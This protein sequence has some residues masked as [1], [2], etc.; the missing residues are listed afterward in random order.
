MLVA[1]FR[2]LAIADI[3]N[4]YGS[5]TVNYRGHNYQSDELTSS[6]QG[7]VTGEATF[8]VVSDGGIG[9]EKQKVGFICYK[10]GSRPYG[11]G[12]GA[13]D[14]NSYDYN[15]KHN[16]SKKLIWERLKKGL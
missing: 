3:K 16:E 11:T 5:T 8:E 9:N 2:D 14:T 7:L 1:A 15:I 10:T 6:D 13:I 12:E 4:Y